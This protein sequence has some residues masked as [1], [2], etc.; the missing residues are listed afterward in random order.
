MGGQRGPRGDCSGGYGSVRT[1]EAASDPELHDVEEAGRRE[2]VDRDV[3]ELRAPARRAAAREPGQRDDHDERAERRHAGGEAAAKGLRHPAVG[4]DDLVDGAA[5]AEQHERQNEEPQAGLRQG[6]RFLP[7]AHFAHWSNPVASRTPATASASNTMVASDKA[8]WTCWMYLGFM[9]G[10]ISS[11]KPPAK[12]MPTIVSLVR[13]AHCRLVGVT[14]TGHIVR[15]T[16]PHS[17][18]PSHIRA[19]PLDPQ[20][21]FVS[22]IPDGPDKQ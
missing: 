22:P 21:S 14:M 9:S 19:N 10:Q 17:D 18:V 20:V 6:G 7:D 16:S 1:S 5:N 11:A 8:G 4:R 13:S 15:K 2:S 12:R 3:G